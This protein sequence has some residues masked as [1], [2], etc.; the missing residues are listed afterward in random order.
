MVSGLVGG[1]V[2]FISV[3]EMMIYQVDT[4]IHDYPDDLK[5]L[6]KIRYRPAMYHT[7]V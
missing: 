7:C 2:T 6:H 5:N 4:I 3:Q 1:G